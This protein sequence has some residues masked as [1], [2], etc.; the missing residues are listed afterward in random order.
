MGKPEAIVIID[1]LGGRYHLHG[2]AKM[3]ELTETLIT[4][5]PEQA[6]VIYKQMLMDITNPITV[7]LVSLACM[8]SYIHIVIGDE[9]LLYFA[10]GLH[11]V[12]AT[13]MLATLGFGKD[14]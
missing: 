6:E 14:A 2:L 4:R 12:L 1:D 8:S 11:G 5:I 10:V 13:I 3:E 7:L 9:F